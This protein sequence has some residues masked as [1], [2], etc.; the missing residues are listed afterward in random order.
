M[1]TDPESIPPATADAFSSLLIRIKEA[2]DGLDAVRGVLLD[3][4]SIG[5]SQKAPVNQTMW[6]DANEEMERLEWIQKEVRA[7]LE[8]RERRETAD[9]KPTD[10]TTI[11][12]LPQ[13]PD[14]MPRGLC[15]NA[16]YFRNA[17]VGDLRA[18]QY[19]EIRFEQDDSDCSCD[20]ADDE[21][22]TWTVEVTNAQGKTFFG[23]SD[24]FVK[25]LWFVL[26]HSRAVDRREYEQHQLRR[27]RALEKL[28]P[29][30]RELLGLR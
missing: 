6:I 21:S 15:Q 4:D 2:I 14:E 1:S 16:N 7:I 5:L 9:P 8:G 10:A 30:E 3:Y 29:A 24:E 23:K 12:Q 13:S 20:V 25:A 18:F 17:F 22:G 28:T 11:K 26:Q 27:K 19:V